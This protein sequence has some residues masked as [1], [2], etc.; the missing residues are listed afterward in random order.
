MKKLVAALAII[1]LL[2]GC[3]V[4][5]VGPVQ[6]TPPTIVPTAIASPTVE[7]IPVPTPSPSPTSA[8]FTS[9]HNYFAITFPEGW[10]IKDTSKD[11]NDVI[12]ASPKTGAMI[13][14]DVSPIN[15]DFT[16]D[17]IS[18]LDEVVIESQFQNY[19]YSAVVKTQGVFEGVKETV[20]EYTGT[21]IN[22]FPGHGLY[23]FFNIGEVNFCISYL[24]KD[25]VYNT[26]LSDFEKS[27][28]TFISSVA[29]STSS[30]PQSSSSADQETAG[31]REN[32]HKLGEAIDLSLS[33]A[34]SYTITITLEQT[35]RGSAAWKMVKKANMF[36]DKPENGQEYLLAK[37]KIKMVATDDP[38]GYEI[39][40]FD[41][42]TVSTDGA[43]YE[44][45]LV[46]GM[47][48][49]F[50]KLYSGGSCEGYIAA[51]IDKTDAAPQIV[52]MSNVDGGAWFSTVAK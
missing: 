17:M 48:P 49:D 43:T 2:T 1:A 36:N 39:N 11:K 23:H 3:S 18:M 12:T 34:Y 33:G 41:F 31:T 8:V 24:A 19:D 5:A 42:D 27:F 9:K 46:A 44:H 16:P 47:K 22:G 51:L 38:G 30:N 21:M 29:Q 10:T 13:F 26:Y 37:F 28:N 7:P 6:S 40:E 35:I 32:P 20:E 15:P 25:E 14:I 4:P 45:P 52:F 50:K